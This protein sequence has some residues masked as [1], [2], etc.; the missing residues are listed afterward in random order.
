[1][2]FI[3]SRNFRQGFT[4]NI[5]LGTQEANS[6]TMFYELRW[7]QILALTFLREQLQKRYRSK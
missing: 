3:F 7:L 6:G 1:M 2:K 4:V 5:F